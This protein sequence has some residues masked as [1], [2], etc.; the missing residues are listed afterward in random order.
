[1]RPASAPA[2][3]S[4]A[5]P[6]AQASRAAHVFCLYRNDDCVF[7]DGNYL[8]RNVPARILWRLLTEWKRDG[9]IEFTNREL[10]LDPS[11][12]LP[13][14]KDNLESRLLLLKRRLVERCP[15][16]RLAPRGRGRFALEVGCAGIDLQER[17]S[18]QL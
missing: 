8:I 13:P 11:L 15:E 10:R 14:I 4:P 3:A 16:V 2:V 9:R 7:V 6:V 12:G 1:V 18:A 17:D 5:A